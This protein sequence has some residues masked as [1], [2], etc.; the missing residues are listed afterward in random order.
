MKLIQANEQN[1]THELLEFLLHGTVSHS[2]IPLPAAALQQPP[3]P[4]AIP[5]DLA[6]DMADQG[7]QCAAFAANDDVSVMEV[8]YF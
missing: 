8:L 1:E 3:R 5:R 6:Y 2:P 7:A 4:N